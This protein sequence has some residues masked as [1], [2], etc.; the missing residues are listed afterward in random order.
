LG[1]II[2]RDLGFS[3]KNVDKRFPTYVVK[4]R[5]DVSGEEASAVGAVLTLLVDESDV[6]WGRVRAE[7]KFKQTD[8]VH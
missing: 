8:A 7:V 2:L 5:K 3:I 4:I 6:G 1:K